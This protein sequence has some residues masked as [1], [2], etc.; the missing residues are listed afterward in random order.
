ML[1][2]TPTRYRSRFSGPQIE[3]LLASI[4]NKL[5]LGHIVNDYTGG[6]ELVASAESVKALYVDLQ[7]FN[8]P[9]Y[10]KGL[11]TSIPDSLIFTKDDKKRLDRLAG[12]FQGSFPD[13]ASRNSGVT[14]VGFKGGEL[15]FI[16]DD[17]NGLQELSYWDNGSLSWKKSQFI[18][19]PNSAAIT[20]TTNETKVLIKIDK[21]KYQTSKY[22]VRTESNLQVF[23]FEL[24]I[25]LKNGDVF[26][27][28]SASLGNNPDLMQISSIT[29]DST[30]INV[31]C[32]VGANTTSKFSKIAEM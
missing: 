16:V 8:D 27:T 22:L 1:G 32:T 17:G 4:S 5:E 12:V 19:S 31:N 14:T 20:N 2:A 24:N 10:I 9:N 15:T 7:Q 26:W 6:V 30:S 29:T 11:I 18:A 21:T 3:E 25:I 28:T 23:A 13:L